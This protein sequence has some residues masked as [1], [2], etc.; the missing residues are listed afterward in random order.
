[1]VR[2]QDGLPVRWPTRVGLARDGEH[3]IVRFR[4]RDDRRWATHSSRD[5]PLWE[6]EVVE[7]FLAPGATTPTRYV[8]IEVNPLGAL[9]DAVV[10]NPDGNPD[11]RR[12]SLRVDTSWDCPEIAWRADALHDAPTA[13]ADG[14]TSAEPW[15]VELIVPWRG[16]LDGLGVTSPTVPSIWRANAYRVERPA[17]PGAAQD[18]V[19]YSAWSPTWR[20]PADFHVPE[21]F[22]VWVLDGVEPAPSARVLDALRA[23]HLPIVRIPR[24]DRRPPA[25]T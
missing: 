20:D 22:G 3:L 7:I 2:A 8:E 4:C 23:R 13:D 25:H 15:S 10:D 5:A 24:V 21:R 9:F 16:V 6:E 11:G 14:T 18:D 12:D 1:M 19:E 17:G